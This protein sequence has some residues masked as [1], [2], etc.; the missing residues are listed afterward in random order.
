MSKIVKGVTKH[1]KGLVKG[2]IKAVKKIAKSPLGKILLIV[3]AGAILGPAVGALGSSISAAGFPAMGSFVTSVG[4]AMAAPA[5]AIQSG[6]S[7]VTGIQFGAQASTAVAT[8]T[9]EAGLAAV[10][11]AEGALATGAMDAGIGFGAEAAA[12][13][14]A[15]PTTSL[16]S[17]MAADGVITQGAQSVVSGSNLLGTASKINSAKNLIGSNQAADAAGAAEPGFDNMPATGTSLPTLNAAADP[18]ST[19]LINGN[20]WQNFGSKAYDFAAS[21]G[22]KLFDIAKT[23]GGGALIGGALKGLGAGMA[24]NQQHDW[25]LD[26]LRRADANRAAPV[27]LSGIRPVA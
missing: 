10:G 23:D 27:I 24:A 17:S 14:A 11:T 12:A 15:A 16:V 5:A 20:S 18:A 13:S 9:A 25:E 21:A 26:A 2:V 22:S 4:T 8:G 6:F 1:L 3:A 19:G 7:A